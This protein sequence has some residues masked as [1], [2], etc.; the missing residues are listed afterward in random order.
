MTGAL[1][2]PVA[3][4]H[5]AASRVRAAGSFAPPALVF[6]AAVVVG[7]ALLRGGGSRPGPLFWIG[8]A[9]VL[10]AAAATTAVLGGVFPRPA[11]GRAGTGL[12]GFLAAFAAWA[13]ITVVWSIQPDRSWDSFNR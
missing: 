3:S 13:G 6:A 12:V 7:G 5:A 9:A 2:G 10:A 8:S 1:E 4:E 11:L